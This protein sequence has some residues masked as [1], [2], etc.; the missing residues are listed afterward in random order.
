MTTRAVLNDTVAKYIP[1]DAHVSHLGGEVLVNGQVLPQCVILMM[2]D[3][4]V[5]YQIEQ[6]AD[7]NSGTEFLN[8][9]F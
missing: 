7:A 1:A 2:M 6:N 3:K 4:D 5:A 9:R 8:G